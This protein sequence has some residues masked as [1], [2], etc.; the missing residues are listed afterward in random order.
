MKSKHVINIQQRKNDLAHSARSYLNS[1]FEELPFVFSI[2]FSVEVNSF[3]S[4]STLDREVMEINGVKLSQY[5]ESVFKDTW[6]NTKDDD[7]RKVLELCMAGDILAEGLGFHL[8]GE[9]QIIRGE[10]GG[11]TVSEQSIHY[12]HALA[13]SN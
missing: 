7:E 1:L 4:L 10:D 3:N 11:F 2:G 8:P 6:G 13:L 12:Q 9:Y 5:R